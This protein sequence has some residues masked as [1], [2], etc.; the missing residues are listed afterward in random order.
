[1]QYNEMNIALWIFIDIESGN[2]L[3]PAPRQP[4]LEWTKNP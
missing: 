3:S 1:M 2:V 4:L